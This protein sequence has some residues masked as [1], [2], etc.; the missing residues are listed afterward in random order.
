MW[1]TDSNHGIF[2][3][4]PE[5]DVGKS[6]Q[7][8]EAAKASDEESQEAHCASAVGSISARNAKYTV[9]LTDSRWLF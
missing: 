2:T 8:P 5:R 1:L 4:N 6:A 7:N 9:V 3:A